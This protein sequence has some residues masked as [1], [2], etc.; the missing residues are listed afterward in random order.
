MDQMIAA[1]AK[2]IVRYSIALKKG[3]TVGIYG[4]T[5]SADL[6][7]AVA[8]EVIRAG[9]HPLPRIAL[10][11]FAPF[12]FQN[13]SQEQLTRVTALDWA[14]A[15]AQQARVVILSDANTRALTSV[16]PS[17]IAA[18]SR[19]RR[20]IREHLVNR[21]RWCLTLHPTEALA[22]E[23]GMSLE[24]YRAFVYAAMFCDKK[25]PVAEWTRI[26]RMQDRLIKRIGRARRVRITG[27][28]TDLAFSV[29]GRLF[30][31]STG[32]HNLPSGEIFT[33]PVENSAEGSIYFDI[34]TARDGNFVEGVRLT[35]RKGRVVE[36]TAERGQDYL[37]KMLA[38]DDGAS[39]LGE[40]G[41]GTN[42][43]IQRPSGEILFDEKIGGSI[44]LALG[45]S[46][47]ECRGKNISALHWDMIK[48]LRPG[49]GRKPGRIEIDG[50]PLVIRPA[51]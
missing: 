11:G 30:V 25:N 4:N 43:G 44:H 15:R 16:D 40:F 33:A 39:R 41:I 12:F 3:E 42:F 49:K 21:T 36:A 7:E 13:A 23:A 9:G 32:T 37:R 22:Q 28:E 31:N 1:H 45:S 18:H 10:P 47:K 26:E 51:T 20:K 19:A 27:A 50:K 17:R 24:D 38:T 2:L 8:R 46:Y 48:D 5:L 6:V 34:P 14:E 35:F 29:A